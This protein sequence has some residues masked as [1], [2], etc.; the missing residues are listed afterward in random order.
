[1]FSIYYNIYSTEKDTI[2]VIDSTDAVAYAQAGSISKKI[3]GPLAL[4]RKGQFISCNYF[5]PPNL[6]EIIVQ[7]TM[8]CAMFGCDSNNGF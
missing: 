5:C 2:V 8:F 6:A 4:K 1:M 7:C 3:Q